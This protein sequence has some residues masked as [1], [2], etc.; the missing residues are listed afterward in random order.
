MTALPE[1]CPFAE[2]CAYAQD[3]CYKERPELQEM[4]NGRLCACHYPLKDYHTSDET[5]LE[6][7]DE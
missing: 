3:L 4:G 1:G 7:E 6:V 5:V 2:R